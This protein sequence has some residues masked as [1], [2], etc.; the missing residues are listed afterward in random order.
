MDILI[1]AWEQLFVL[2]SSPFKHGLIPF[3]LKFIP[4]VLFLE[5]PVYFFILMGVL[6]YDIRKHQ[7]RKQMPPY[8]PKVSCIV[9][10]YSEGHDIGLSLLSLAEQIYT[11]HIEIL[12]MIDGARQNIDTYNAARQLQGRVDRLPRRTL[13]VIPKWQRGGRVSSLNAGLKLATGAIVLNIDGDT[14]FDNDMITKAVRHFA[15]PNVVGVAGNL[16]VRNAFQSLTS[17]MQAIEYMLSIHLSKIGLSEFNVINN[18]SGAF[19]VYRKSF[20]S[21]IGG[22]DS[23]TAEDLDLTIRTKHYFG[24]KTGLRMI[25]EPEAI[26]H[27]EVPAT[28]FGLLDQRLRW[29]G[30]LFYLYVRKHPLSFT[31]RILGWRNMVVMLWTGLFFQIVMPMV[32]VVYTVY[33]LLAYPIDVVLALW[34]LVYLLYLTIMAVFFTVHV[35]LVSERKR[36]D[37][38][39]VPVVPLVPVFTFILRLWNAVATIKEITMRSHLDSSMAPWWVLKRTKF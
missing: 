26:G 13:R 10:G 34:A 29:D 39:L 7:D 11:G 20:V 18:I 6:K 38:K 3:V 32:I 16:R 36:Q 25:F 17:R 31:P 35:T 9:M 24:R 22:W 21:R 15:D 19:G 23:G 33:S 12:A 4:Y 1:A 27:T 2:L 8:H 30:D 37:L 5:M 14:S 28:F